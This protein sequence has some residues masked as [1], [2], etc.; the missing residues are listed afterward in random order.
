MG[1]ETVFELA[2]PL[3]T[4]LDHSCAACLHVGMS[5]SHH[6]HRECTTPDLDTESW[7]LQCEVVQ[8]NMPRR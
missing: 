8:D 6:V 5:L 2:I 3:D 7:R 1:S 4:A